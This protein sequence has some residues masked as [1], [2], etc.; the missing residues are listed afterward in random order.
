[1][2]SINEEVMDRTKSGKKGKRDFSMKIDD[3]RLKIDENVNFLRF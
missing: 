3:E 1:M 2:M